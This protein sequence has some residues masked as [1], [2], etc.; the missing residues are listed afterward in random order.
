MNTTKINA[1]TISRILKDRRW[2][3]SEST[4][5]MVAT[6][7]IISE[8]FTVTTSADAAIVGHELSTFQISEVTRDERNAHV[9]AMLNSYAAD[10]EKAGYAVD[11][12][13]HPQTNTVAKL[14]VTAATA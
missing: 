8:G 6:S 13:V 7:R 5:G 11:R 1:S 9:A 10:I 12:W 4:S 2:T 14:V 3:R